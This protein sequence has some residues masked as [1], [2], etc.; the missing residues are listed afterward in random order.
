MHFPSQSISPT[1]I[2]FEMCKAE[3][4][5]GMVAT[6]PRRTVDPART[7]PPRKSFGTHFC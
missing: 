3:R 2:Q 7:L 6:L 4:G 1:K 5:A